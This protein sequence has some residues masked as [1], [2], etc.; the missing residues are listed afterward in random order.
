MKKQTTTLKIRM[1]FKWN[2]NEG[3][4]KVQKGAGA[5]T[6]NQVTLKVREGASMNH[7]Q[8]SL[9]NSKPRG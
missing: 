2:H 8:T 4:L 3:A 5:L 1:G 6:H 9:K 7:N